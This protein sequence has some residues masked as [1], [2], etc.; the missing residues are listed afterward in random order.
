VAA[1]ISFT[2]DDLLL[3]G[4]RTHEVVLPAELLAAADDQEGSPRTVTLRPLV[5]GD[6][7]RIH[8]AAGDGTVLTSALMVQQAVVEPSMTMEQINRLPAGVVLFLVSEIN[9]VSG[10]SMES[11]ELSEAVQAPVARACFVLS[12]HFGWTPEECANL[13]VGQVLLYLEM[14]GRDE[15]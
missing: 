5:L 13:T 9:R 12:S 8:K 6:V 1:S 15:T 14:L 3:G 4:E 11:D 2:A 10:L 7:Q